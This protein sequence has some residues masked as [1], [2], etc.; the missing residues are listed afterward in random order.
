M[1]PIE[2]VLEGRQFFAVGFVGV[3]HYG[4]GWYYYCNALSG[5]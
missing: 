2:R 5:I 3:G 4:V 1:P